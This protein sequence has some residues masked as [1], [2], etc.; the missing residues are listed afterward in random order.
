MKW[1]D[2][3]ERNIPPKVVPIFKHAGVTCPRQRKCHLCEIVQCCAGRWLTSESK[4]AAESSSLVRSLLPRSDPVRGLRI[5]WRRG[6]RGL[7]SGL[8]KGATSQLSWPAVGS[9]VVPGW[10][11]LLPPSPIITTIN[12]IRLLAPNVLK[13]PQMT[14]VNMWRQILTKLNHINFY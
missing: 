12:L 13:C 5:G 8:R 4:S 6:A 14:Q 2:C 1:P 9:S 3:K 11:P 7:T 10:S